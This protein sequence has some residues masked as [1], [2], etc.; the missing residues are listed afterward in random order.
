MKI[1]TKIVWDHDGKELLD[2]WFEYSGALALAGGSSGGTTVQQTSTAPWTVQQP[3]L[4][5]CFQEA[6]KNYYSEKPQYYGGSTVVPFSDATNE[7]RNKIGSTA[8]RDQLGSIGAGQ[9]V[10]TINGAYNKSA[11]DWATSSQNP[12]ANNFNP[13]AS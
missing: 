4:T 5:Q 6:A 11:A 12:A 8:A 13:N 2:D 9:A 10:N 1:H 3:Y 7:A